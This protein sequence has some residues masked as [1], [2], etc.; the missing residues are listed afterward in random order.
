MAYGIRR[1]VELLRRLPPGERGVLVEVVKMTLESVN[2]HVDTIIDD[3]SRREVEIDKRI[4]ALKHEVSEREEQIA[5]RRDEIQELETEQQEIA[6]VKQ[7]LNAAREQA[8]R[9]EAE[10]SELLLVETPANDEPPD[11][12]EIC[13]VL[14]SIENS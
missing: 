10:T 12:D 6:L 2:V 7:Q 5:T 8:E 1:A 4:A 9:P 3:A 11:G 14:S 13:R